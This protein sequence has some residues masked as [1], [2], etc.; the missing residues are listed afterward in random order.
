MICEGT[1]SPPDAIEVTKS[2]TIEGRAAASRSDIVVQGSSESHGFAV[3]ADDVKITHMK[4]VGPGTTGPPEVIIPDHGIHL[5]SLGPATYDDAKFSD[6][7]ITNWDWG[8]YVIQSNESDVG[9]GNYIHGNSSGVRIE[10]GFLGGRRDRVLDNVIG[11]N[12]AQG[13]TLGQTDETYVERNT[14]AGNYSQI[15]WGA[16]TVFI[17]NN[18]IEATSSY[19]LRTDWAPADNLAQIGGSPEHANNFI[20]DPWPGFFYYIYL[21]CD[22]EA[23]LDASYNYWNGINSAAGISATVFNDEYDDPLNANAD[24]PRG[25]R[26]A[27]VVHPWLSAMW[28][29]TPIPT[30]SPTRT[31]TQRT[32]DLSPPGW[33][34]LAWSGADS[35]DPAIALACISGK[36]SIAYG[37]EG[38]D[39]GF[40]RHVEGCPVPG[41][42]NMAPL[43]EFDS[44]FVAITAEGVTC[45]MLVGPVP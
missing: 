13:I 14:L 11:P 27:V 8:V 44:L 24:C 19:G 33:H 5:E 45:D 18:E 26:S 39:A 32:V 25:D 15:T 20:G 42:C 28:T 22:A 10:G 1:Y 29:P 2:L 3:Q 16:S 35:T 41:I 43:N 17:W 30:A 21:E 7:E 9:P 38:P 36:Y 34:D 12:D 31:A 37:W 23:T 6:L 4:L 40:T